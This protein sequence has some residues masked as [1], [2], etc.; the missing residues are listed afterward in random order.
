MFD[1]GWDLPYGVYTDQLHR[2]GSLEL[3]T[4]R[5]PLCQGSPAKRLIKLNRL[6][7]SAGWRGTGIWVAAQAAGEGLNNKIVSDDKLQ[8]Y[9]IKRLK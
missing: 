5:F 2:F 1:A 9:W 3:D 6:V 7:K 4:E 8:Q